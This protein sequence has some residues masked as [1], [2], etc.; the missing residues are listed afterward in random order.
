MLDTREYFLKFPDQSCKRHSANVVAENLHSQCDSKG[1]SFNMPKEIVDHRITSEALHGDEA[2][3]ILKNRQ[4]VP[5]WTT[6]ELLE[7]QCF[8]SLESSYKAN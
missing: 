7:I 1:H 3:R 5:K 4:K 2:Y 8:E 6:K